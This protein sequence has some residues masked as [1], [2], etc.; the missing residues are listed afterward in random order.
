MQVIDMVDRLFVTIFDHLNNNCKKELEA[1]DK[2]YPF[3]P[4]KVSDSSLIRILNWLIVRS[5]VFVLRGHFISCYLLIVIF[6]AVSEENVGA[7]F[8]GGNTNASGAFL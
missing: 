5:P 8:P 2:Q 3:E 7:Q 4:L 1:I 6:I